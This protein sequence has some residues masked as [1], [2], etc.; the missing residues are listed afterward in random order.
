MRGE[1][2]PGRTSTLT[3][4]GGVPR[5]LGAACSRRRA[6]SAR[7]SRSRWSIVNGLG[8]AGAVMESP[9]FSDRL[10]YARTGLHRSTTCKNAA[11]RNPALHPVVPPVFGVLLPGVR[12]QPAVSA[13][14]RAPGRCCPR[15]A[16]ATGPRR[17]KDLRPDDIH[18]RCPVTR[19]PAIGRI[20][21]EGTS[22]VWPRMR[23]LTGDVIQPGLPSRYLQ[24]QIKVFISARAESS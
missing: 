7:V 23:Y 22:S 24:L 18:E 12:C 21:H 17:S 5:A 15:S 13:D 19:F 2:A 4:L 8:D 10:L 1:T 3:R 14:R 6:Q 20:L 9:Q 11:P 16:R